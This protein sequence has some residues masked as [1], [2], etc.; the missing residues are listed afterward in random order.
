MKSIFI[1]LAIFVIVALLYPLL[2]TPPPAYHVPVHD[3]IVVNNNLNQKTAEEV[4]P[5]PDI[6]KYFKPAAAD[7]RVDYPKKEIGACPYSKPQS[8]DLPIANAPMCFAEADQNMHL[9]I[10]KI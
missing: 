7:V 1:V 2:Q 4:R 8:V 3:V 6:D 9:R 5:S 10:N